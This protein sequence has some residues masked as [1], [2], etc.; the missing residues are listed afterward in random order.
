MTNIMDDLLSD[1]G[2]N[3]YQSRWDDETT[4]GFFKNCLQIEI[5]S[6][7]SDNALQQDFHAKTILY[8][9]LS[10]VCRQAA[11]LRHDDRDRLINRNVALGIVKLDAITVLT[12]VETSYNNSLHIVLNQIARFSVPLKK[13]R[14]NIRAFRKIKHNGK[15]ITLTNYRRAI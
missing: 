14:S 9:V 15:Y 13:F 1:D 2:S 4:V 5:F 12:G 8:N 11:T 10:Y 3:I 6:G 7:I